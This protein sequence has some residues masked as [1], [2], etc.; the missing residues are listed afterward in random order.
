MLMAAPDEDNNAQS[1]CSG[2]AKDEKRQLCFDVTKEAY[3]FTIADI[4]G[5]DAKAGNLI[6]FVGVILGVYAAL[7]PNFVNSISKA[8]YNWS[9]YVYICSL[10]LLL[11]AILFAI[12]AYWWYNITVV[13]NP[14]Y[15]Y[16]RYAIND[17]RTKN[18]ILDNLTLAF[19][20]AFK[21]NNSKRKRKE[22]L[23]GA[24][25]IFFVVG[26]ITSV[27]FVFIAFIVPKVI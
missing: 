17:E 16:D 15:F 19:V 21:I 9:L 27:I 10:I 4:N 13:P 18:D 5:L 3:D 12:Y 2:N 7:G 26:S 14:S 23:V 25:F 1:N 24:S 22:F 6:Y 8:Y 20:E 11:L